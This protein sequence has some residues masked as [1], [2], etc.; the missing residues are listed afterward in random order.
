M[1]VLIYLLD[2]VILAFAYSNESVFLLKNNHSLD[3]Q[4]D[5]L[6]EC[7]AK[8]VDSNFECGTQLTYV[9]DRNTCPYLPN[10]NRNCYPS[11]TRDFE[12]KFWL[13]KTDVHIIII[14]HAR[15][16]LFHLTSMKKDSFWDAGAK[17]IL[18]VFECDDPELHHIFLLLSKLYIYNI[19]VVSVFHNNDTRIKLFTYNPFYKDVCG[20]NFSNLLDLEDCNDIENKKLFFNKVPNY[21]TKCSFEVA[22]MQEIPHIIKPNNKMFRVEGEYLEG[23]EEYM[24]K[25][26][27]RIERIDLKFH[28][29]TNISSGFVLPN[30]T[31]TGLL[32]QL[33]QGKTDI[34][35]GGYF[36]MENRADLY[37]YIWGYSYAKVLV[38]TPVPRDVIWI[39]I[40]F[41]GF[42]TITWILAFSTYL[43]VFGLI[44]CIISK[45]NLKTRSG[46]I[47]AIK[48]GDY[49]FG[50][51]DKILVKIKQLRFIL[52]VWILF[53]FYINNFY[54]TAL[55]SLI[56][57]DYKETVTFDPRNLQTIPYEPCIIDES[58]SFFLYVFNIKLPEKTKPECEDLGLALDSVARSQQ[59]YTLEMDY[60]FLLRAYKYFDHDGRSLLNHYTFTNVILNF[61]VNRGFPLKKKLIKHTSHIFE[62]GLIQYQ[63]KMLCLR[64]NCNY[65][66][67]MWGGVSAEIIPIVVS[68]NGLVPTSLKQY[69]RRLDLPVKPMTVGIQRAVLLDNARIVRR[70][71]TQS[72]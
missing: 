41:R 68:T 3:Y 59:M 55:F 5:P 58:K 37:D 54:S 21:F 14:E 33:E 47:L 53:T 65:V 71:L 63:M 25:I 52:I 49:F 43:I 16:V 28:Y 26:M 11:L 38:I 6:S 32:R 51:A 9:C 15:E 56:T 57:S 70:F 64:K 30:L 34:V 44:N 2:L 12:T 67:E 19:V 46:F 72:P 7:V 69:L 17:F 23:L 50:H 4:S 45:Y 60:S 1:V 66:V 13:L 22:A 8:I 36:L 61:Y 20:K 31:S 18:V 10:N 24:L 62:S 48:L 40:I 27:A 35:I 39:K 29:Y 42:S